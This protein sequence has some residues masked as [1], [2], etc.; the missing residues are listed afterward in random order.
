MSVCWVLDM[1]C[2]FAVVMVVVVVTMMD[3]EGVSS[4]RELGESSAGRGHRHKRHSQCRP[5]AY[6]V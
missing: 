5:R 1:F 4:P 2:G 6:L 3:E